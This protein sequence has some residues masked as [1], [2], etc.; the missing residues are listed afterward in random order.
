MPGG[1]VNPVFSPDG[2]SVAFRS[3]ADG[4]LKRLALSGGAAVTVCRME[5]LPYGISWQDDVIVFGQAARGVLRVSQ[6]G[7]TPEVIASVAADEFVEGPQLLPGNRGVMFSVRK[8]N[9][10]WDQARIVV[11]PLDGGAR[12]VLI[13]G[14]ADG[15][16][17]PTGHFAYALS[18]VLLVAPFD[19][20]TLTLTGGPV[21]LVEGIR[22]GGAL[23]SGT[24]SG[25]A[26]YSLSAN[27]SLAY[28]P[29]PMIL[30]NA[31][32]A[33]LRDVRPGRQG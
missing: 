6:N 26:R 19:L 33:D 12:R 11:Q 31:A 7:G 22:R 5:Q 9:E 14:G 2:Q 29:G 28:V 16:H 4:T 21:P 18:G 24:T 17:L 8:L 25:H 3:N 27:G 32:Q 15:R 20:D 13:E 30:G 23:L 1:V 10:T